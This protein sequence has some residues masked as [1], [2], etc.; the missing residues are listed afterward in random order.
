MSTLEQLIGESIQRV[1][2]SKQ[3]ETDYYRRDIYLRRFSMEGVYTL[4]IGVG[5]MPDQ[6]LAILQSKGLDTQDLEAKFNIQVEDGID[7]IH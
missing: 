7:V 4:L 1:N 6:A 5:L 3:K 2:T